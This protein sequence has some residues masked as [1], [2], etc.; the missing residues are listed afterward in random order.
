EHAAIARALENFLAV[1][2]VLSFSWRAS[3]A[4]SSS[5]RRAL[6]YDFLIARKP[7]IPPGF[8][9]RPEHAPLL[10]SATSSSSNHSLHGR[11]QNRSIL[12]LTFESLGTTH[13]RDK[14]A[15]TPF[16]SAIQRGKNTLVS[17]WHATP[18]PLTNAAHVAWYFGQWS[19][20]HVKTPESHVEKLR[21]AGYLP[22]YLTAAQTVHY[23][24]ANL[25]KQAG[26]AQVID[27]DTLRA[28]KAAPS[29]TVLD[30]ALATGGV[31][32]FEQYLAKHEGP[33]FLHIHAQNAHV[34][35]VVE[36]SRKY[37]R[38]DKTDDLGR[39]LNALEETDA[40]FARLARNLAIVARKRHA[41][42]DDPILVVTSDHGQSFG[43]NDYRSHASAVTAEQIQ[44]P[45]V[46]HHSA[47]PSRSISFSSHFDI[48]P[49]VLDL[50][51]ISPAAGFGSSLVQ[52]D[53]SPT[54]FLFD[55]QPSRPTSSCLGLLVGP[56]KYS[57]DLVRDTLVHSTWND[58]NPQMLEGAEREY[59]EALIGYIAERRGVS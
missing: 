21:N 4:K 11:L 49:T 32:Q 31:E 58:E 20:R 18:A 9:P 47:L 37:K 14:G 57:L 30:S 45:F 39:F 51:G 7:R 2:F 23:G 28:A 1:Y 25:L 34:P 52:D 42:G 54:F 27:A 6:W 3:W 40:L 12:L 10:E 29:T 36:D 38:H 41:N 15:Q 50:V 22:V 33:F 43:E 44:V 24:L 8:Q 5:N 56:D 17:Q 16:L 46:L 35:Y 53:R 55:G 48:L 59:F 13:L 26:F 19:L